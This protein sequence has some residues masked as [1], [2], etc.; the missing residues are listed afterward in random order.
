MEPYWSY[1]DIGAFFFVLVVVAV[2]VRL[3]IRTHLLR[4][5]DL[6]APSLTL[7]TSII[8]FL[9]IALYAIL[10]RR[11]QKPVIA[12]LGWV[13]PSAF[14]TL[15]AVV[16]GIALALGIT[17]FTYAQHH[18]MPMIPTLDFLVLGLLLGPILEESVFRGCLLPVVA[19]TFGNAVSII[20][21]AVLFAAFHGPS[22]V[23][24]WVWFT[25]TGI[26]Y[27][28]LRLASKTTTASALMHATCNL[29]LFL[30]AKF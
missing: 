8:I 11:H 20:T 19:H 9:G 30:A 2:L 7:Q 29:T 27:G 23:A 13:A 21:T 24:H 14:Y 4:P 12:P 17:V 15:L 3:G 22:D 1:E 28:W 5:S 25:T 6:V 16:G 26:G 18:V 10:K